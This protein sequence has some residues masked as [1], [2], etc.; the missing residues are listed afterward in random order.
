MFKRIALLL[1]LTM[2]PFFSAGFFIPEIEFVYLEADS[3]A[4]RYASVEGSAPKLDSTSISPPPGG[5]VSFSNAD[6]SARIDYDLD[7]GTIDYYFNGK[8]IIHRSYAGV[9]LTSYITS[10]DY[11]SRTYTSTIISDANGTGIRVEVLSTGG[12]PDMRQKFYIYDNKTYILTEVQIESASVQ[13][14][15]WMGPVVIDSSGGVDIGPTSDYRL[16]WVPFDNDSFARYNAAPINSVGTS[17]EVSAFYDN[18]SRNGIVVG[19]VEHDT[20]KTGVYY[21][22]S[23]NRLNRLNVF[24]GANDAAWTHD[25]TTHGKI[26]G[27]TI[28]SPKIFVSFF[29]DWRT[30]LETY[31][32]VNTYTVDKLS[33]SGGVPF[34]WNSWGGYGFGI[35]YKKA[36]AAADFIKKNLMSN[37]F[38]SGFNTVNLDSNFISDA[39][40]TSFVSLA[41]KNGQKAGIY[42]TPFAYWGSS[43]SQRVEGASN[44]KYGDCVLRDYDGRVLNK[45]DGAYA[46]DPSH[47]AVT[48]RTNYY[49]DKFKRMGFDYIKLDFTTHGSLEGKHYDPGIKTGVQAYNY[50]MDKVRAR[51][52]DSMFTSLSISPLF[53]YQYAHSRR[54]ACD[55]FGSVSESRYMLNSVSYGWWMNGILYSFNDPDQ[56]TLYRKYDG[57][58]YSETAARTRVTGAAIAGTM[59]ID[60]DDLSERNAQRRAEAYLTNKDINNLARAGV[61][62]RAVEGNTGPSAADTFVRDDGGNTYYIAV[63]NYNTSKAKS[64]K[65]NLARAGLDAAFKYKVKELWSGTVSTAS[66]T[67]SVSLSPGESRIYMLYP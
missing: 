52:G 25:Q 44:Y 21:N 31:A 66:G 57:S 61:A 18:K 50:G 56:M 14:S 53:P 32:T 27:N 42:W 49:I 24:G 36:A 30:G 37:D 62:F 33:W 59:F 35:N 48:G 63:F 15:N 46:L 6:D 43:L 41:H 12:N 40:L 5:V 34:G 2:I 3:P 29:S 22:G 16:L 55:T 65:V 38:S 45:F 17:F 39:E 64:M 26:S 54:I 60:G 28:K 11:R 9:Q 23:G 19:S 67:L 13:S 1:L 58:V 51:I 7:S 4:K 47:P 10:R 8:L 20:W